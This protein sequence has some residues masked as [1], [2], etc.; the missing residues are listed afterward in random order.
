MAKSSDGN[1]IDEAQRR[2]LVDCRSFS[3]P[4]SQSPTYNSLGQFTWQKRRTEGDYKLRRKQFTPH[5]RCP[6]NTMTLAS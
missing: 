5:S 4:F 2:R 1:Q 3:F 6:T